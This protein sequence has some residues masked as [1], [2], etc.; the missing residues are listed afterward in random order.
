MSRNVMKCQESWNVKCH[1]MSN[2]MKCQLSWNVK[3]HEMSNAMKWQ[4]SWNVMKYWCWC[5]IFDPKQKHQALHTSEL[6]I[7]P[8]TVIFIDQN[9]TSKHCNDDDPHNIFW[10]FYRYNISGFVEKLPQ[11]PGERSEHSC[12]AFPDTGVREAIHYQKSRKGISGENL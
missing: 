12:A 6:T 10:Q 11:L 9:D 3:C 7:V 2:V 8:R 5:W 1:E 4:M